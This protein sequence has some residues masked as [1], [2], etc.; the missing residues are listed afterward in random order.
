M[1][2]FGRRKPE[3]QAGVV[4]VYERKGQTPPYYSVVC[5]CGWFAEPVD[6]SYP[7]PVIEQQMVSAACAHDPAADVSVAFPLDKP[8]GG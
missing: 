3:H 1:G 8:P 5:R 2:I 6:A 4:Y 7:D